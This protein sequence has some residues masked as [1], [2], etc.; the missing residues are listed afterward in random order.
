MIWR[1]GKPD[2][3]QPPWSTFLGTL[4][5]GQR[6]L[7]KLA[8]S[9]FARVNQKLSRMLSAL[10]LQHTCCAPNLHAPSTMQS[11]GAEHQ[12]RVSLCLLLLQL[13]GES[14][15]SQLP[16]HR[17]LL[18][19]SPSH[20]PASIVAGPAFP[21]SSPSLLSHLSPSVTL[22]HCDFRLPY[23]ELPDL[24]EFDKNSPILACHLCSAC[25]T[26]RTLP[27]HPCITMLAS[28]HTYY[29]CLVRLQ[30][31]SF[32]PRCHH[33]FGFTFGNPIFST[34]CIHHIA[35]LSKG[36]LDLML[37]AKLIEDRTCII[38]MNLAQNVLLVLSK[39]VSCGGCP[40]RCHRA[41]A[42]TPCNSCLGESM[43]G[44]N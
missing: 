33:Y 35:S 16:D 23:Q 2:S 14:R 7:P 42:S 11:M 27:G 6:Y 36:F 17:L 25:P 10:I 5:T 31:L 26:M 18:V 39:C 30:S 37:Q 9:S 19:Y 22:T 44:R 34:Q 4:H 20:G 13:V 32:G 3:L 12:G 15:Y 21:P 38:I 24:S 41:G 40:T 1:F 29:K 8:Y 43:I 28:H